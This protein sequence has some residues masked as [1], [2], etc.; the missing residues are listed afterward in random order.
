MLEHS[1]DNPRGSEKINKPVFTYMSYRQ[2]P[3]SLFLRKSENKAPCGLIIHSEF[4][5]VLGINKGSF[6]YII[7]VTVVAAES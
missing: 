4:M 1:S 3:V 5:K 7:H 2:H 6:R